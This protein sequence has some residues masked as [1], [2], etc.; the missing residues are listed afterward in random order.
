MK[1]IGVNGDVFRSSVELLMKLRDEQ[2]R[3]TERE[4]VSD[5]RREPGETNLLALTV[6]CI[7]Y[8]HHAALATVQVF[9]RVP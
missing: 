4:D 5:E 7:G 1:T 6:A 9:L 8:C 2:V 3:L